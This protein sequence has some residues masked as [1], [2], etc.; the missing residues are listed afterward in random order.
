MNLL[1]DGLLK[2]LRGWER[3]G[4]GEPA[5]LKSNSYGSLHLG[6][7]SSWDDMRRQLELRT[8]VGH[9]ILNEMGRL[10]DSRQLRG[11]QLILFSLDDIL[12]STR[13]KH[14]TLIWARRQVHRDREDIA[15][16]RRTPDDTTRTRTVSVPP[17][18]DATPAGLR[19]EPTL[20]GEVLQTLVRALRRTLCSRSMR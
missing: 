11:E 6:L 19:Q 15:V 7:R 13:N 3:A 8:E 10:A 1:N 5:S 16:P 9:V 12:Q 17:G 4:F 20:L 14:G 2:L 18:D